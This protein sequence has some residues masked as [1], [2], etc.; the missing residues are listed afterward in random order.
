MDTLQLKKLESSGMTWL[1]N[2]TWYELLV[3]SDVDVLHVEID[4]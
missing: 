4:L 1:L 3:E 2:E